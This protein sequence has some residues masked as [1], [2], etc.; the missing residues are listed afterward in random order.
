[1]VTRLADGCVRLVT[2]FAL[3]AAGLHALTARAAGAETRPAGGFAPVAAARLLDTKTGVRPNSSVT[4]Q[5]TGRGGVPSSGVGTVLLNVVALSG[6]SSGTVTAFPAGASRP[7]VPNLYYGRGQT[8]SNLVSVSVGTA[9]RVTLFNGSTGTV[10]L[11]LNVHGYTVAGMATQPG[12]LRPLRAARVHDSGVRPNSSVPVQVLGRGGV[13]SAGVAAVLVDVVALSGTSNGTVTAYPLGKARPGVPNL[14]YQRGQALANLVSVPVGTGGRITLFNGSAGT[15]R[16][17]VN[18]HGYTLAGTAVQAGAHRSVTPTR[19]LDSGV[20]PSSPV[21]AQVTGRGGVPSAGVATV[22]VSVVALTGTSSGTVTAYPAG[23]TRPGV[24]NLYYGRGQVVTSPV[25]VPVGAGGRITLYNGSTGSVRL[26]VNVHGYTIHDTTAPAK[27]AG[28]TAGSVGETSLKLSWHNPA[29]T[30]YTGVVIRRATGSVPPASRTAGT[31][32]GDV[33]RPS[34]SITVTGLTQNT[35]YAFALFAHDSVP[36]HAAAATLVVTTAAAPDGA[37]G[38]V[39]EL[40]TVVMTPTTVSLSWVN[41][42]DPSLTGVM[43]RR[44][45]GSTP[46]SSPSVGTLMADLAADETTYVDQGLSAGG[47]YSY[48]LFAHDGRPAFAAAATVTAVTTAAEPVTINRSIDLSVGSAAAVDLTGALTRITTF[49][50]QP[51]GPAGMSLSLTDTGEV[52]LAAASSVPPGPAGVAATGTGCLDQN[53]GI[54]FTLQVSASVSAL[55]NAVAPSE[56]FTLPAPDRVGRADTVAAGKALDDEVILTLGSPQNPGGLGQAQS[57][58]D[59][60][61]AVVTGALEDLGVYELRWA[62]A[63]ADIDAVVT[64]LAGTSGVAAATR[65]KFGSLGANAVPPGDWNDDGEAVK[66]PFEQIRATQAWDVTTGGDITVGVVDEGKVYDD[67]EDLDVTKTL[68]R[69]GTGE[70]ATHVAGLACAVANGKGLVGTAWGCPIVSSGLASTTSEKYEKSVLDA[71]RETAAA[72]AR[73][74][75]IS[76]GLQYGRPD[77]CVT[78]EES[79]AVNARAQ[80]DATPFRFLFNGPVGRNVVWTLSAGNN[81]GEGAHSSRGAN[82][83]LPNVITVAASN[84]DDKLASF[85]N[86]GPGVEVAAP[87]GSGVG[88]TGAGEGVWSTV[89]KRCLFGLFGTCSGYL[90][91]SGT[92]MAAPIVAGV[93]TLAF[94]AGQSVSAADVGTC[95][96]STAGINTPT[97]TSRGAQPTRFDPKLE[98]TG[99]IPIVDAKATVDCVRDGIRHGDVLIAGQGDRTSSGNGTDRGDLSAQLESLGYSVA[100]SRALPDDLSGFGQVWY[101]DTEALTG[102][103]QDRLAAYV[104]SGRSAY[105]TGE[106]GCC[107]VDNSSIALINRLVPGTSVAHGGGDADLVTIPPSAPFG[108]ATTPRSVSTLTTSA[109]GSLTGVA[110]ANVV[111]YG[112]SPDH[113]IAAAWG[114]SDVTG[115]GRLAIVMDINW[116]AEQY[117]GDTWHLFVENLAGFMK[118]SIHLKGAGNSVDTSSRTAVTR[119]FADPGSTTRN[120]QDQGPTPLTARHP[121]R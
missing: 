6:T 110:A 117:R 75:N 77:P 71:A 70:H 47:T 57:L 5:V 58:A 25:S 115:G 10:R 26:F 45:A 13:P 59:T 116:I 27:V 40:R 119:T 84:S 14:Y 46:P 107:S 48:A 90:Q 105:L 89:P 33:A 21:T 91:M 30:D 85:S 74:V 28:V 73:V 100:T 87:G 19:L 36:N 114:P 55:A 98:F 53:C 60:V 113:A 95:I 11:F 97:I 106:W 120:S 42:S 23:L 66:W 3:A 102:P 9:G 1:M 67:H 31:A 7:A 68:G 82:W 16:T 54:S 108:L 15:V 22:L 51:G 99:S 64:Q 76:L 18:V 34:T 52:N 17:M 38:P 8:V 29:D 44:A 78:R 35:Q 121:I 41:P 101:I 79:D 63:P 111:G 61:G 69:A 80:Q 37:P 56:S 43:V 96:T 118:P 94:S 4:V 93:A 50:Q 86:F 32:V 112:S 49:Q 92:S 62:T 20:R 83:A 81:C 2:A 104:L 65:S 103:E 109:P 88:F 72:G 39:T 12:T 24:P